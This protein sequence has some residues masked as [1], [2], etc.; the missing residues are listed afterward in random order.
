MRDRNK[1]ARMNLSNAKKRD[2]IQLKLEDSTS[3]LKAE[4]Y[5]SMIRN[6]FYCQ[7]SNII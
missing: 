2:V 6:G 7:R 3:F 5:G 4:G 1:V